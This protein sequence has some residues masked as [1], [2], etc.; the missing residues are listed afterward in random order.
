MTVHIMNSPQGLDM[1]CTAQETAVALIK[2]FY[3]LSLLLC[4]I[5]AVCSFSLH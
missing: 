3:V 5:S 2:G 1:V 4:V